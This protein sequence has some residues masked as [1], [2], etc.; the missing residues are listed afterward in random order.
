M[1][2]SGPTVLRELRRAG[3][4][5][6]LSVPV[7]IGIDDWMPARGHKYG[8]IAVDLKERRPIERLAKRDAATVMR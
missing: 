5:P 8:T 6:R 4:P 3:C 2:I 1:R 7:V